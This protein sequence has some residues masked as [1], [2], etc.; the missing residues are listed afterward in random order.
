MQPVPRLQ[1]PSPAEMHQRFHPALHLPPCLPPLPSGGPISFLQAVIQPPRIGAER[2]LSRDMP[3]LRSSRLGKVPKCHCHCHQLSGVLG[4]PAVLPQS[5]AGQGGRGG[6]AI[7]TG[8][9]L[10]EKGALA[11]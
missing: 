10:Q 5:Q 8:A 9:K 4:C 1:A 3:N 2:F 7:N 11:A 6:V